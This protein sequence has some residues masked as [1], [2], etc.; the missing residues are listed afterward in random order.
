MITI[1]LWALLALAIFAVGW[2]IF[3]IRNDVKDLPKEL[4]TRTYYVA[5]YS[6]PIMMIGIFVVMV[7]LMAFKVGIPCKTTSDRFPVLEAV[8][9][10]NGVTTVTYVDDT[11]NP[12][13]LSIALS[14]TTTIVTYV[15][16]TVNPPV[17]NKAP[18]TQKEYP[19]SLPLI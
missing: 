4:K 18:V 5:T 19:I 8:S 13:V 6:V 7:F 10:T 3:S 15:D 11:V 2:L 9:T 14:N 1:L 16:D 17:T 12:P